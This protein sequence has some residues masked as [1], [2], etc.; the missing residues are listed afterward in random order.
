MVCMDHQTISIMFLTKNKF[1]CWPIVDYNMPNVV[2]T[3]V[4]SWPLSFKRK[5]EE[6]ETK[7][8]LV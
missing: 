6:D 1:W 7:L 3:M 2:A 8:N 4:A 5:E